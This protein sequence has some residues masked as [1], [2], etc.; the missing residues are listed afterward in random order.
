MKVKVLSQFR[1]KF[2]FS[3]LYLPG[4]ILDVD[5]ERAENMVRLNLAATVTETAEV[6]EEKK[7]RRKKKAE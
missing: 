6:K 2:R 5:K 7:P 4:E 3:R 1:D